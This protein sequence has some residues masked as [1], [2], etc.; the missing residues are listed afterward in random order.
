MEQSPIMVILLCALCVPAAL[1][2]G[3]GMELPLGLGSELPSGAGLELP[4]G[5]G[6]ELP[7]EPGSE[8]PLEPGSELSSEPRSGS[9]LPSGAGSEVPSGLGLEPP[10]EPGSELSSE[11]GSELP[12]EPGSGSELPSEPGS[13]SALPPGAEL[14]PLGLKAMVVVNSTPCSV[15]CGLGVRQE[16]LCEVSPAGERRNCSLVRSRCLSEWICGLRHLSVPEGKPFQLTCLSPDAASLEGPNFGYTWR[17][18]RGLITTNDLLF[19]PFRNPS[20]SLSF[21]PALESHSGTYRCD[22][23][24]LSSFQLV[25]RIYFGLRVIPRDLVDLDFQKSLTWE[26]QLAANGE[27]PPGNATGPTEPEQR[28]NFWEKQWFYEVVLGAGSGVI[29]GIL[30][31]LGLCCLGRICR[32]RAA[33]EMNGD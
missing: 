20:P 19:H 32:K 12:S 17:F 10:L 13:G 23:Q 33:Q 16:R 1:P 4:S 30:F 22:V 29:V 18:A 6:S 14:I 3:S 7:L 26:Q 11:P 28:W 27:E 8:L 9:E 21:S 31:S 15:T 2:L 25:K 24:V 5:P